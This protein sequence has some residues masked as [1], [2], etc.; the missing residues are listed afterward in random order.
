MSNLDGI[1]QKEAFAEINQ[2]LQESEA[3]AAAVI[4]AA[5]MN[6]SAQVAACRKRTEAE[7]RAAGRR[8]ES[9]AELTVATARIHARGQ[10]I[11]LLR[12]KAL[13]GLEEIAAKPNYGEILH[14][15]ADEAIK[16]VKA[17]EAVVVHPND[18]DKL[19]GW[20]MQ[21]GIELRTDSGIRLGA[22]IISSGGKNS[23]ENS[24]PERLD[25]AWDML[26]SGVVQLLWE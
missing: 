4:Q 26:V 15:L 20:A 13:D 2:L 17:P 11:A 5:Q 9:A 12:E 23:V 14:A 6:A 16:A 22:R 18:R 3:K 7:I 19:E 8:A 1:I 24:L 10:V 25:R 21:N